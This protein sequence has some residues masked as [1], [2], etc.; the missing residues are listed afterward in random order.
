MD[1][2]SLLDCCGI[3][4]WWMEKSYDEMKPLSVC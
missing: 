1:K 2:L 3:G 4:W